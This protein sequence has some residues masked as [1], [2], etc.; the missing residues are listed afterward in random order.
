M[1]LMHFTIPRQSNKQTAPVR[2][3]VPLLVLLACAFSCAED[4]PRPLQAVNIAPLPAATA[5]NAVASVTAGG[6]QY[7]IS[8]A[9]LAAGR[10]YTDIHAR[11]YVLNGA[12]NEWT[13]QSAVPG[14]T[15]RLAATAAAAGELAYVFGGYS[16]AQDG[17]EISTPWT[18]SFDPIT[19]RFT[20][21][22][23]MPIPVDDAVSVTYADRYIYLISG[24]HDL[25]NINLVQQYDT[26]TDTWAQAS[27]LPGV[28]LFGHAGGMIGD[29]MF[30]CDGVAVLANE[31]APRSFVASDECFSGTVDERDSRRID[32]RPVSPHPGLPRY[33]MAATGIT[34][35]N[36]ILFVGGSEN[37]YNYD[38]IG[39]DGTPSKPVSDALLF[40]LDTRRWSVVPHDAQPTMDHRGLVSY[41]NTWLT[42]GG[43]LDGQEISAGVVAY[44]IDSSLE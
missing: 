12:S 31:N 11:T 10:K 24:W 21:L 18:H 6:T 14:N 17:S 25:G 20:E 19:S 5:N 33:R 7:V 13:E 8:F 34:E 30:Y 15:G 36:A 9:G 23:P 4:V 44:T 37:P 38:G 22:T 29:T 35:L 42:V 28:A 32:W 26:V 27:P 41:Q 40:A 39:Y 2:K 16:V 1:Q 3:L 43:M